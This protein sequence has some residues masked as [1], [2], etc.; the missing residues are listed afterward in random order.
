[1]AAPA[2]VQISLI[3]AAKTEALKL[4]LAGQPEA[5]RVTGR[6]NGEDSGPLV[7]QYRGPRVDEQGRIDPSLSRDPE[8]RTQWQL[9][10]R[11]N[12]R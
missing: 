12:F 9:G 8:S 6:L 2:P 4:E 3:V 7:Y 11:F 1:M 5:L 10:L